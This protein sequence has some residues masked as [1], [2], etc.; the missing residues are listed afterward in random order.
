MIEQMRQVLMNLKGVNAAY[1]KFNPTMR[2]I[3]T[4]PPMSFTV[5][6]DGGDDIEVAGVINSYTC[7]GIE[8]VG[9]F[10]IQ[11]EYGETSWVRLHNKELGKEEEAHNKLS[12]QQERE[13]LLKRLLEIE[14]EM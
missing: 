1:I 11:S 14:K 6:V 9:D 12:L 2:H 7:V 13:S 3:S 8:T 5:F 4:Y 10:P